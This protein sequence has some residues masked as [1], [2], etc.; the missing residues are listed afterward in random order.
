MSCDSLTLMPVIST[1]LGFFLTLPF[2]AFSSTCAT[3]AT[4]FATALATILF[5]SVSASFFTAAIAAAFAAFSTAI[6]AAFAALAS[7][8]ALAFAVVDATLALRLLLLFWLEV[9]SPCALVFGLLVLDLAVFT[10]FPRRFVFSPPVSSL[11]TF[12]GLLLVPPKS[13]LPTGLGLLDLG[14]SS[15]GL[16]G[17]KLLDDA[18][19]CCIYG[20]SLTSSPKCVETTPNIF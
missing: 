18:V 7:D 5:D 14:L 12:C 10:L 3:L 13:P 4:A 1:S 17:L 6:L 15:A 16:L 20:K 11:A 9:S 19:D 8:F 2:A